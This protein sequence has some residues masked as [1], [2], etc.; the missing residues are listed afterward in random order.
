MEFDAEGIITSRYYINI[1]AVCGFYLITVKFLNQIP[2]S[3]PVTPCNLTNSSSVFL[4]VFESHTK[5]TLL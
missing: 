2:K 3:Q 1:T 5:V 4:P